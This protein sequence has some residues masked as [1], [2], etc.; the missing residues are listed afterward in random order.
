MTTQVPSFLDGSPPFLQVTR[1]TIN[2]FE[3][4]PDPIADNGFSCP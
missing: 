2:E 3:F 1:I 4:R